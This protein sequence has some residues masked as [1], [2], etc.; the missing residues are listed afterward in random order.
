MSDC[1]VS[2]CAVS[3][4]GRVE[5]RLRRIELCVSDLSTIY[6]AITEKVI[7]ERRVVVAPICDGLF[8]VLP[9]C[10]GPRS[11]AQ[12]LQLLWYVRDNFQSRS[13]SAKCC[14]LY[15]SLYDRCRLEVRIL[16]YPMSTSKLAA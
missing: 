16:F 12:F 3:S 7:N 15:A 8:S 10:C 5:L 14:E 4:F 11:Y 6:V 1:G 9:S 2:S 13:P